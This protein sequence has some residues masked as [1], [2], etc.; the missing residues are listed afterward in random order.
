MSNSGDITRLLARAREGDHSAESEL[1]DAIYS[2]LHRLAASYMR[3]ERPNHTLQPSALVNEAYLQ[4]AG[5][6]KDITWESRG[7]FY[8]AAAKTMRR[9]LV[10]HARKNLSAKRG[11]HRQK[12]DF[13]DVPLFVENEPEIWLT[14]DDAL[15]QLEKLDPRQAKIV[16]LR[17][18]CGL[19]VEETAAALG[20][21]EKTVKRD[22]A[23]SR[24]WLQAEV[25]DGNRNG[26]VRA[27]G[28]G[29]E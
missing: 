19:T 29:N 27:A 16:E 14:L 20:V 4:L 25:E 26:S 2:E 12:I 9:I 7:H 21:S 3:R 11:G 24:A 22:W 13:D 15:E 18:F 6:A 5:A 17:F 8:A 28:S 1:V 23:I 10:D